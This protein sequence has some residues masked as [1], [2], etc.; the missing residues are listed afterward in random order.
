M[1]ILHDYNAV[2]IIHEN[3]FYKSINNP[4]C[5]DVIFSNSP[6]SFHNTLTFCAG[7]S[8]FHKLVL[9][10]LITSFRKTVPKELNCRD[11]NKLNAD[12]L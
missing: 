7:L 10:V 6:N 2:H 8:D 4:S 11:Y 5:T 3:T 12:D 9:T 1:Q